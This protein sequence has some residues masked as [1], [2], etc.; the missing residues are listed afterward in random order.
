MLSVKASLAG[1]G[2]GKILMKAAEDMAKQDGAKTSMR[3]V[4]YPDPEH[5]LDDHKQ[6]LFTW[7]T[8][9]GYNRAFTIDHAKIFPE[10]A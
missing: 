9:Q 2:Y 8:K 10:D 6:F 1:K 3:G 7:Y 4:I 5:H